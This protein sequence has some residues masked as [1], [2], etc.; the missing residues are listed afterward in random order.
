MNIVYAAPLARL[1][2]GSISWDGHPALRVQPANKNQLIQYRYGTLPL[3]SVVDP[4]PYPDPEWIRIQ[5]G[6]NDLQN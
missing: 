5:E 1:I 6:K 3:G 4:D 2:T